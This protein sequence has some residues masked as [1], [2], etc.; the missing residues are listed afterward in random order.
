MTGAVETGFQFW[1]V[2]LFPDTNSKPESLVGHETT[3]FAPSLRT[4]RLGAKVAALTFQSNV[5]V[6]FSMSTTAARMLLAPTLK[7][8]L[9][10]AL[11]EDPETGVDWSNSPFTYHSTCLRLPSVSEQ[12]TWNV[13]FWPGA[14]VTFVPLGLTR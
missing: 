13:M 11:P 2:G 7:V 5:L 6:R 3:T 12:F 10:E 1:A 8:R 9:Q 4:V 14:A